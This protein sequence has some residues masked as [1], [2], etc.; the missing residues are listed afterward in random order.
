MTKLES[1]EQLACGF[2]GITIETMRSK[3]RVIEHVV[4]R[5][6][7]R[8]AAIDKFGFSDR[9]IERLQGTNRGTTFNSIK[10]IIEK[11]QFKREYDEFV[12][13]AQLNDFGDTF[14][15]EGR[16]VSPDGIERITNEA[17]D[18]RFYR[19]PKRINPR[20]G[21]NYFPAFHFITAEGKPTDASLLKWYQDK[22]YEATVILKRSNVMGSFV[23][24]C[25][26]GMI[27]SHREV[28]HAQIHNEFPD[29]KEA[30]HV[31]ECLLGFMNFMEEEQPKIISSEQVM[32]GEDFGFTMDLKCRLK[33]DD[34]KTVWVVDWKTSKVAS[35]DHK[36]Q[37]EVLRR[38][39]EA[40]RS[41]VVVLGNTTKKKY[42]R[43]DVPVAKHD[44]YWNLFQAIKETAYIKLLEKGIIKPREDYMPPVFKVEAKYETNKSNV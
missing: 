31:K 22:G 19:H 5:H 9:E 41:A 34:Y 25:I 30:H 2:F 37:T 33:S 12:A 32:C 6:V 13:F 11:G 4:P 8:A 18:E 26:D 43:T 40:D 14:S 21:N 29:A 38:V 42:T 27:K 3:D 1:L 20:T 36:M 7:F 15:K 17:F 10:V 28:T 35:D 24:D 44:Y 39:C 23:H 16:V